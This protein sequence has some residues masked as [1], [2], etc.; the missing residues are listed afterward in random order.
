MRD[1]KKRNIIIGSLCCLLV[2]M[3]IGYALLTQILTINGTATLTGS[4]N[5]Y[6]D[7]M[8][9]KSKS[10]TAESLSAGVDIDD[11][12]KASFELTLLKPGDY[13]EYEVVVKNE[14]SVNAV[15]R[16][17][18][19]TINSGNL[20]TLLTHTMIQGQILKAGESTTFTLK[21]RFDERAT[22]IPETDE[23]RLT[24]YKI[25][26]IYE[27]YDGDVSSIPEEIV[28]VTAN[29]CFE[30]DNNGVLINYDYSCGTYVTVP[31]VVDDIEVT[32]ISSTA[33]AHANAMMYMADGASFPSIIVAQDDNA[34]LALSTLLEQMGGTEATGITLFNKGDTLPD[35]TGLTPLKG[36]ISE[37]AELTDPTPAT[38]EYLDLSQTTG[39]KKIGTGAFASESSNSTLKY[40]NIDGI[41]D[42][43]I[44]RGAFNY[45]TLEALT[46]DTNLLNNSGGSFE[47]LT[48]NTLR[49]LPSEESTEITNS[50]ATSTVENLIIG[51]GITKVKQAAFYGDGIKTVELPSTLTT[52][53]NRA[54][55]YNNI[56]SLI[57]PSSLNYI[58]DEAFRNN[59][60]SYVRTDVREN[61][62]GTNI[63]GNLEYIGELAFA[64]NQFTDNFYIENVNTVARK[65]FDGSLYGVSYISLYDIDTIG[66]SAFYHSEQFVI[67]IHM[68]GIKNIGANAFT[69][70]LNS[71]T[72]I[73]ITLCEVE[74]I[75]NDAFKNATSL[76]LYVGD[77]NLTYNGVLPST[78]GAGNR[79]ETQNGNIM[80]YYEKE[81]CK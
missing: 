68:S 16:K 45:A 59:K 5:I 36:N 39:L 65:A 70:I 13:V 72:S 7:S 57:L 63:Y 44:E 9:V 12:T 66:E 76:N 6:I 52:I 10:L 14:G 43:T 34:F 47:R 51:K 15:L 77:P 21:V 23:E 69:G 29:D 42:E 31:A 3:G 71:P 8:T 64:S 81:M 32:E 50:I 75:G 48:L 49:I 46:L 79:I 67:N 28:P 22:E 78:N 53:E 20:D 74:Y 24:Q 37:T 40:L 55:M 41:S 17:L 33:F 73:A 60:I 62:P 25:Q 61:Y 11:P 56:E 26:L 4:W 54:F 80:Y 30:V 19:P 35:T 1:R 18:E 27:Q 38:I 58:G 2:F